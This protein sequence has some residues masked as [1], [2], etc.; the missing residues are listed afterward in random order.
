[1]S[2]ETEFEINVSDLYKLHLRDD[3]IIQLMCFQIEIDELRKEIADL[4]DKIDQ[5]SPICTNNQFEPATPLKIGDTVEIVS[6]AYA[7]QTTDKMDADIFKRM[8]FKDHNVNVC[9][10]AFNGCVGQVFA[11]EV[12]SKNKEILYGV[13]LPERGAQV[14]ITRKGLKLL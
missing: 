4:S 14:L 11:I 3:G 1:M 5:L 2:Q 10:P 7:Y 8:G 12:H 13:D 6:Y 9:T